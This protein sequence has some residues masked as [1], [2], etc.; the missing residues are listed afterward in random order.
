MAITLD[1]TIV[2]ARDKVASAK[3]F[4]NLF[5]LRYDGPVGP[6]APVRVNETFTMDFDDRWEH[7]DVITTPFMSAK[8]SSMR[9]SGES[10]RLGLPTA[11]SRG[12]SEI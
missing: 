11:A 7:F 12:R 10:R 8:K 4:A 5:A 6:F 1:H 3:F 2:P 9:F